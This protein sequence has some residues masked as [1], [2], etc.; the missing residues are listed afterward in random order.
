MDAIPN[1]FTNRNDDRK[2]REAHRKRQA[3]GEEE[4]KK[5]LEI[6][7]KKQLQETLMEW[8]GKDVDKMHSRTRQE[9]VRIGALCVQLR[10]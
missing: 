1:V 7:Y 5:A 10:R 8:Y 4:E 2:L 3:T 9:K 6:L